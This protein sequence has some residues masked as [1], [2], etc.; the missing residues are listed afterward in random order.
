MSIWSDYT[1]P[2]CAYGMLYYHLGQQVIAA[3]IA[4]VGAAS[5]HSTGCP[6]PVG[7]VSRAMMDAAGTLLDV[8]IGI[9]VVDTMPLS[10]VSHGGCTE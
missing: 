5:Q 3:P 4:T 9:Q 1:Y 7:V 8:S 6:H 10:V 2:Q